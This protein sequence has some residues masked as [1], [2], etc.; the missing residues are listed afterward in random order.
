MRVVDTSAWIEWLLLSETGRKVAGYLPQRNEWIVPT[1]VQLELTKWVNRE[2]DEDRADQVIAYTESCIVAALDTRIALTAANL[3][4]SYKLA[5][6]D[7]IVYATALEYEADIL[8][9]DA[10]FN[11]LPQVILISKKPT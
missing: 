6:A 5:T 10:H 7:A 4:K 2:A 11:A 9:C 3:S 8:T 1:I